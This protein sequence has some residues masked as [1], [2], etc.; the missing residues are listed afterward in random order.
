MKFTINCVRSQEAILLWKGSKSLAVIPGHVE[1]NNEW[2]SAI[3]K[4]KF[5][6]RNFLDA[7]GEPN[8]ILTWC[9]KIGGWRLLFLLE[10][11]GES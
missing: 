3:V 2:V 11:A 7:S 6:D 9:D 5:S 1:V 4:D 8:L 10:G